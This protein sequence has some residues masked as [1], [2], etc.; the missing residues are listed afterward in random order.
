[1]RSRIYW[2][3]ALAFVFAFSIPSNA[4]TLTH[5]WSQRFGDTAADVGHAV[6]VDASGN[7]FITGSFRGTDDF[8]GGPLVSAGEA[9]VF[10]AKYDA[11]GVHQWSKRFGS[12]LDDVGWALTV[13][14]S[15]HVV[16]TGYF[17]STVDFGGGPLVSAGWGDSFVVKFDT[18]GFHVWSERFGGSNVDDAYAILNIS[19]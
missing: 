4:A 10:L 13:D 16:I 8:G 19:S 11:N 12:S 5:L 18:N 9:D 2:I 15:G 1:M 14:G 6:A 17:N 7:V 3:L